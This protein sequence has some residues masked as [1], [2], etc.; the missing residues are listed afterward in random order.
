LQAGPATWALE[1]LGRPGVRELDATDIRRGGNCLTIWRSSG[2]HKSSGNKRLS[3][4]CIDTHVTDE[5]KLALQRAGE[6]L[7]I[8]GLASSCRQPGWVDH[9]VP[10]V[11][12][13]PEIDGLSTVAIVA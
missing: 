2:I 12:A 5:T 6:L 7:T 3:H 1:C 8:S 11:L 10:D 13:L 4:D 9:H